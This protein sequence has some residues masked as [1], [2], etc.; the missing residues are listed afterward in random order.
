MWP[1]RYS[2]LGRIARSFGALAENTSFH[3]DPMLVALKEAELAPRR[4]VIEFRP[5]EFARLEQTIRRQPFGPGGFIKAVVLRE[6]K[7]AAIADHAFML[8]E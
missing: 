1:A 2:V 8:S 6:L 4:I 7:R 3:H 5:E